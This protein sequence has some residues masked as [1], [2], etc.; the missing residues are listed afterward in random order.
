MEVGCAFFVWLCAG[1]W[2]LKIPRTSISTVINCF[3]VAAP[4][5][6]IIENEN[7]VSSRVR[8][9]LFLQIVEYTVCGQTFDRVD[10]SN[11]RRTTMDNT[12]SSRELIQSFKEYRLLDSIGA[13]VSWD[14]H[15][16][17]PPKGANHRAEQMG[18]LAKL[19]HE[20]LTAPRLGELLSQVEG[21][22]LVQTPD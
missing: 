16:Y 5:G 7:R 13:V 19:G 21:S 14:Q 2:Q 3:M 17:M 4:F 10:R 18:Y 11:F 8:C 20:R 22:P 1:G 15:T 6:R 9:L 12:T